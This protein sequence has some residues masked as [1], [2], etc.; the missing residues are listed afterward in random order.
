MLTSSLSLAPA[1]ALATLLGSALTAADCGGDPCDGLDNDQDGHVDE[2]SDQDGDGHLDMAAC[3][4][5]L[6]DDCD[7]DDP[8]V[9]AGSADGPPDGADSDCDGTVDEAPDFEVIHA[10]DDEL[11]EGSRANAGVIRGQGGAFYG[12]TFYGGGAADGTL[13]RVRPDGSFTVLH[14][15][16][17]Q[18]GCQPVGRLVQTS[19]GDLYGVTSD[20]GT[21]R[22]GGS[23]RGALFRLS[24][25]GRYTVLHGFTGSSEPNLGWAPFG[26][27]LQAS[28]GNLYG[29]SSLGGIWTCTGNGCSGTGGGVLYR[30]DPRTDEVSQLHVFSGGL[31]GG[32]LRGDLIQG[33]D[34]LLYGVTWQGGLHGAG[35]LYR[36]T[37]DGDVE[38]LRHFN[39]AGGAQ[40]GRLTEGEDGWIYGMTTLG[41]EAGDGTI[42]RV[43]PASG[44]VE[45]IHTFA[46]GGELGYWPTGWITEGGDGWLY[47]TT[48][49][50]VLGGVY[51]C[52]ATVPGSC[53]TTFR[54]TPQ[55][56]F[57]AL[58]LFEPSSLHPIWIF[59]GLEVGGDGWMYGTS[60]GGGGASGSGAV[61]RFAL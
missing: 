16:N 6:G 25:S 13:F 55:G 5:E 35:T 31:E 27:L 32:N 24:P 54:F 20:C 4:A 52:D 36:S 37:L 18:D 15:F 47:G 3:P 40:A 43:S 26:G 53:G 46:Y 22:T 45:L 50:E 61:F 44:E 51:Y 8:N 42:Y 59:A 30:L 48:A 17:Y 56:E 11:D 49:G 33:S 10:I 41:G 2:D 12:T 1:L 7:D 19:D 14:D 38:V 34:G 57:E 60:D 28:D 29:T 23:S 39:S 21:T 58:H 9:F